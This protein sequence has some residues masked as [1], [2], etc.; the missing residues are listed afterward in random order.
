MGEGGDHSKVERKI[1]PHLEED[2]F[3][4]ESTALSR[5]S[6]DELW[7]ILLKVVVM[8]NVDVLRTE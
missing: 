2:A 5:I 4:T 3:V 1:S 8:W 6:C 7:M